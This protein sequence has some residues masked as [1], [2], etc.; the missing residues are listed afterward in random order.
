MKKA[1]F[2]FLIKNVSGKSVPKEPRLIFYYESM[3][4]TIFFASN[5]V[6]LHNTDKTRQFF[7]GVSVK[8]KKNQP[9]G[10]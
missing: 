6:I 2:L 9:C 1:I 8:N 4:I 5:F 3:K 7:C 10:S